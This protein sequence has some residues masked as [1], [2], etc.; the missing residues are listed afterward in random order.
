MFKNHKNLI[1]SIFKSFG[2]WGTTLAIILLSGCAPNLSKTEGVTIKRTYRNNTAQFPSDDGKSFNQLTHT[3]PT[4]L[5]NKH[6]T[7][8]VISTLDLSSSF[9]FK[10]TTDNGYFD[11]VFSL[12]KK[13][14][15]ETFGLRIVIET[16][17]IT[18][19]ILTRSE[20]VDRKS[21]V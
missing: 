10:V 18:V 2:I 11:E 21:V 13:A 6:R 15:C 20:D 12:Q 4:V 9:D 1:Q 17:E 5:Q 14:I 3:I 7:L 8:R 19:M 16:R